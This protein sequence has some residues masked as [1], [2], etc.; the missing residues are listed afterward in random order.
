MTSEAPAV[1][2]DSVRLVY[3]RHAVALDDVT[4]TLPADTITGLIGRNGAGKSSLMRVVAGREP[5]FQSGQVLVLGV[6][7]VKSAPGIVHLSGGKWPF[8]WE[9]RIADLMRHLERV[10]A[11]FDRQR[12]LELMDAFGVSVGRRAVTLS[13]GQRAAAYASLA[14]ASR[15]PVTLFDEPQ[16]GMDAPSRAVFHRACVEEQSLI[17]RTMVIST[18]LIDESASLF[19]RVVVLDRGRV[20][21]DQDADDLRAHYARVEGPHDTVAKLPTL[22]PPESFGTTSSGIVAR[23]SI[24][25]S[26]EVRVSAV[27]LQELSGFL[28]SASGRIR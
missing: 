15:A 9:L 10:H 6:P 23:A 13:R 17:P 18:H 14:L 21:A 2:M 1:S 25:D 20:A 4:L 8:T 5:G 26:P 28:T 27:S 16:M 11:K 24:P 12:A 22:A 7:V 19:E 3:G